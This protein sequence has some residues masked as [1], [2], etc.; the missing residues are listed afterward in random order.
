MTTKTRIQVIVT[1]ACM[2]LVFLLFR[3][4]IKANEHPY[5]DNH[6][7]GKCDNCGRTA[8]HKTNGWEYCEDDAV[9]FLTY[10]YSQK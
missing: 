2:A 9:G 10:H 8:T 3:A 1:L 4:C 5:A 6:N 7:D